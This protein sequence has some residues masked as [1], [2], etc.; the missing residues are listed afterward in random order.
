MDEPARASVARDVTLG[1]TQ[2]AVPA[3]RW[4][5]GRVA[6]PAR[7]GDVPVR[8]RSSALAV[9]VSGRE[10]SYSPGHCKMHSNG[11]STTRARRCPPTRPRLA[12]VR[13]SIVYRDTLDQVASPSNRRG[14]RMRPGAGRREP[15]YISPTRTRT[16]RNNSSLR[17][18][19]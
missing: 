5:E 13:S 11:S 14:L 2:L 16:G 17:L 1:S 15:I 4:T 9:Q 18:P 7:P 8:R 6:I 19:I 10:R 3:W 12:G